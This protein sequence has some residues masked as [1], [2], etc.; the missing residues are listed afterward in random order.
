MP[1]GFGGGDPG[2]GDHRR[3]GARE[4]QETMSWGSSWDPENHR[5]KRVLGLWEWAGPARAGGWAGVGEVTG[6]ARADSRQKKRGSGALFCRERGGRRVGA[7]SGEL[8]AGQGS[9]R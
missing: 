6:R 1:E 5:R 8:G 3:R 4:G 7:G 2:E 9:W